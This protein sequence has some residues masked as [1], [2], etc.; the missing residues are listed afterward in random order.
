MNHRIGRAVFALLVGLL[1]VSLSYQW[2]SNPERRALRALQESVVESA[3]EHLTSV[4]GG[5]SLEI[6]D[7]LFPN[8]KAGKVYVYPEGENWAVSGHYRRGED[9]RWHPFLMTLAS[10]QSMTSLKIQ[11]RDERL[12][13]RA[14][15]DPLLEISS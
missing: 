10:D 9:D 12:I 15:S 13:E 4:V 3:R 1:V 11:D 6:V 8:R 2:I 14:G 5:E 7:P